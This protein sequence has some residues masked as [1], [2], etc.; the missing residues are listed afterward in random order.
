MGF[1]ISGKVTNFYGPEN[2]GDKK[3]FL[4]SLR[5]LRE[6]MDNAHWVVEGDFNLIAS[7]EEK[8]GGIHRLEEECE[9][10]RETIEH[11]NLMDIILGG[12]WFTWNNKRTGDR[13]LAS[14]LDRFLVLESIIELGSEI[15][16]ATLPSMGSD[17][18]PIELMWSG[19]GS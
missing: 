18:W 7:L 5:R 1:S 11:L 12:G 3:E 13:N 10:F 4:L 16:S 9:T 8:K 17:H 19:L 2:V 14:R 6:G 15:H